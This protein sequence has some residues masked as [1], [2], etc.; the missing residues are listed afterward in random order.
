MHK[1]FRSQAWHVG[2]VR[3]FY[4]LEATGLPLRS[5]KLLPIVGLADHHLLGEGE[6][7]REA[8]QFLARPHRHEKGAVEVF[9]N[10]CNLRSRF[11]EAFRSSFALVAR[12]R[13]MTAQ[14]VDDPAVAVVSMSLLD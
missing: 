1:V 7:R 14:E 11:G 5:H 10:L 12:L 6:V 3:S 13:V 4:N 9:D 2:I 8:D